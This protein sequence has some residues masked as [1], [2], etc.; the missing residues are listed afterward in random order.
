LEYGART[1]LDVAAL[2]DSVSAPAFLIY[3]SDHGENLP[4]DHN[5]LQGHLA[6]RTS[7][8]DGTVPAFVLW[9]EAM[10]DTGRPARLLP[11]LL[12]ARQIAHADLSKLFLALAG[13]TDDPVEPTATPST[14]G[15]VSVGDEYG[16]VACSDLKP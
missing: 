16:V 8:Q 5:G 14:W 3:T 9:N 7:R 4:S 2:L 13:A 6:P 15:R 12:A 10:A 1:I 11:K